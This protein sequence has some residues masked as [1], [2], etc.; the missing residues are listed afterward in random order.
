MLVKNVCINSCPFV[1]SIK[2]TDVYHNT[3][4]ANMLVCIIKLSLSF[5]CLFLGALV[6]I[7]GTLMFKI[8]FSLEISEYSQY[9]YLDFIICKVIYLT[10]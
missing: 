3:V 4:F 2:L 8:P 5:L 10:C 7:F 6:L 1:Q 9:E